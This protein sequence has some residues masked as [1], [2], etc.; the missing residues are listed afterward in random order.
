MGWIAFKTICLRKLKY[1][2]SSFSGK[3]SLLITF[4]YQKLNYR[5]KCVADLRPEIV[6]FPVLR[7]LTHMSILTSRW[8]YLTHPPPPASTAHGHQPLVVVAGGPAG[9]EGEQVRVRQE[10][11]LTVSL[12]VSTDRLDKLTHKTILI[13]WSPLLQ[14]KIRMCFQINLKRKCHLT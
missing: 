10:E 9:A 12:P 8:S 1:S 13:K 3:N 14:N 5:G 4:F 11:T 6:C 7:H 2:P